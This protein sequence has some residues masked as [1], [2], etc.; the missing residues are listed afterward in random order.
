MRWALMGT[1]VAIGALVSACGP[2]SVPEAEQ[3]GN[4]D[5]LEKNGTADAVAALG[6]LADS[7][8]AAATAVERRRSVDVNAHLAAW[9]AHGRGAAWGTNLLKASLVDP[10]RSELAAQAMTRRDPNLVAFLPELE[11]ALMRLSGGVRGGAVA[12][13]LASIGPPAHA[14]VERRLMDAKTRGLMCDGMA[15][16]DA[17]NDAKS[18]LLALPIQGRDNPSCVNVVMSLAASE[19]A[20]LGWLGV[21]AEP[22]LL[23]AAGKGTLPC[24]RMIVA[25]KRALLERPPETFAALTVPL[26]IAIKRCASAFDPMLAEV[27]TGAPAARTAIVMALDPFGSETTEM[28]ATCKALAPVARTGE[29]ARVRERAEDALTHACTNVK[30]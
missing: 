1:V 11:Q 14:A 15:G 29:N 23:N 4:V 5:W 3:K 28:P 22:G 18:T 12:A 20:V 9:Q 19:D 30:R 17:S 7:N 2:S 26:S 24:P 13:A 16:P 25:W 6:R 8:P 27:L 10:T 21:N